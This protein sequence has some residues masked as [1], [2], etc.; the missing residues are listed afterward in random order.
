MSI[1]AIQELVQ[2]QALNEELLSH[3]V[4]TESG[5]I[6][7]RFESEY[8]DYKRDL[9]D[10]SDP[11]KVAELAADVLALHNTRG[12]YLLFGITD[13]YVILGVH[14]QQ[15]LELDSNIINSKLKRFVGQSFYCRY[16]V[17]SQPIGGARRSIAVLFIPPRKA[18]GIPTAQRAPGDPPLFKE[19]IFFLRANDRRK[20]AETNEEFTFLYA[21]PE[22]EVLVG[23]HQL[24]TWSPKPGTRLFLGDY[25]RFIGEQTRAP[26]ME[27]VIDALM[28]GKW[29]V[30]LLRGVGGVGKTALAIEIT[31]K[32]ALDPAYSN[33][34]GG[35]ISLSAKDQEL[36][37][38][39]RNAIVPEVASYDQLLRQII[40]HS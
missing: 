1:S 13:D 5:S 37:P 29:D 14:E 6:V 18:L 15:A 38:Y 24:R 25:S 10:L 12:G 36:T 9:V 39:D 28:F 40:I 4:N 26:R 32:L 16:S 3:F 33:H 20:R 7:L 19:G 21:A 17:L 31:R 34:F 2:K 8:W 35:I 27:Q 23:S 30:V 11:I 22:P